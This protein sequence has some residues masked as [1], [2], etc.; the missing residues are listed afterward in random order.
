M[1]VQYPVPAAPGPVGPTGAAGNTIRHGSGAPGAGLGVNGDFYINIADP[2]ALIIYGPKVAGAW[3]VG[4]PL[5][6][7]SL[8]TGDVVWNLD[9]LFVQS[10]G[11]SA[12]AVGDVGSGDEGV[13]GGPA[14][15]LNAG[16]VQLGGT[17]QT[18]V[19]AAGSASALPATPARYIVV[20]AWDGSAY[21]DF[22]VPL[23]TAS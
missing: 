11:D 13:L 14:V 17:G 20:K 4:V 12:L 15:V 23:Y 2:D 9:S 8:P 5:G 22:A 7:G 10:A 18:T 16:E 6:G 1:G 21:A 19:G 3:G